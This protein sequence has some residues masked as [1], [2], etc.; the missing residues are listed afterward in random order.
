[1][2]FDPSLPEAAHLTDHHDWS[3]MHIFQVE[4]FPSSPDRVDEFGRWYDEVHLPEVLTVDGFVSARRMA[5]I[6]EGGPFIAQYVLEGDPHQAVINL[7]AAAAA[8]KL[9]MSDVLCLDPLPVMHLLEI[10][11][12]HPSAN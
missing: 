7:R 8:G 3:H 10:V 2:V 12:E 11:S 4:S 9:T 6:D 5:P 1:M